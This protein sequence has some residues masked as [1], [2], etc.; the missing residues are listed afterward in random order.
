MTVKIKRPLSASVKRQ[1]TF[2]RVLRISLRI[3]CGHTVTMEPG[4]QQTV[5]EKIDALRDNLL[6][7]DSP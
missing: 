2:G 4:S 1:K 7:A 3:A 6:R 5:L